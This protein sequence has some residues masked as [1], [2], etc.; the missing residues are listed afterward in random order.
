VIVNCTS[1]NDVDGAE[2]RPL[3]AFAVNAF[4]VRNL[5]RAAEDSGARL[6]HYSTDFVF[7]GTADA[8]YTE[9]TMPSPRS[10]YAASKLI[11]EWFALDAPGSLVLRVERQFGTDRAW[12]GRRGSLD[13]IVSGLE[14][15][16]TVRVFSDRV[17]SP[18]YTADVAAATR[19]LIDTAVAP[20]LYH[21]VNSGA[22]TWE[23]VAQE[24]ARRLGVTPAL[25]P[26]RMDQVTLKAA[27]PRYC[28]LANHKLAAAGFVMPPW[29]DALARWLTARGQSHDSADRPVDAARGKPAR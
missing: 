27:R 22:A 2:D 15:G 1:F 6:V 28:A 16:R 21:C 17:V 7:D 10:T 3:D 8:P 12:T 9:A 13:A 11:G 24:T 26:I 19:H 5:A 4:A 29:Q 14:A 20:G 18:S 25:E 23:D